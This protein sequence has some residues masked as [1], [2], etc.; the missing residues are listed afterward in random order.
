[1]QIAERPAITVG[2]LFIATLRLAAAQ[3]LK[4]N[5]GIIHTD[6]TETCLSK[7]KRRSAHQKN[8]LIF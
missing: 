3:Q 8:A 5:M 1:M 6:G 4:I 2:I 7:E